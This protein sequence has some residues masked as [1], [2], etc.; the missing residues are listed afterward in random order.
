LVTVVPANTYDKQPREEDDLMRIFFL[1]MRHEFAW[2][3]A[4]TVLYQLVSVVLMNLPHDE[5]HLANAPVYLYIWWVS[6]LP[7]F[8]TRL[9]RL[10]KYANDSVVDPKITRNIKTF[11]F[12]KLLLSIFWSCH[13]IGCLYYFLA[14]LHHFDNTTWI[15]AFVDALPPYAHEASEFSGEYLLVL[16]KG[17]C[18]VAG[19]GYDPG[20]PGN[21]AE[22]VWAM[23]VM[24]LSVCISSLILGTLLTYLVRR[25][26]LEVAHK[27]RLAALRRYMASK[28]VPADMYENVIRY[29]EFQYAKSRHSESSGGN[30]L[31]ALLS[32]S[33]KIEVANAN[34]RSPATPT[35]WLMACSTYGAHCCPPCTSPFTTC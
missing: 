4:P 12:G 6:M 1:F 31:I 23:V 2:I 7:R 13:I 27:D 29:C 25:D 18:R 8:C 21:I 26:P 20:L 30:D 19:L 33:L 28:H 5:H 14:R 15:S 16:F 32:P 34:Y 24:F 11:Q 17:F 22:L 10:L 9:L 35:F 3:F